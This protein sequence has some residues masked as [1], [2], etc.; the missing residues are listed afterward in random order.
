MTSFSSLPAQLGITA[1]LAL[2]ASVAMPV[3]VDCREFTN[4]VDNY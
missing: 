4:A 2:V 1:V 3:F